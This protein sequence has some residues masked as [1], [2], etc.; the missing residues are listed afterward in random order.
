MLCV[1]DALLKIQLT[2]YNS[3]ELVP[4]SKFTRADG[5]KVGVNEVSV[6][7]LGGISAAVAK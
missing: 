5:V 4:V 1:N 6:P 3:L 2:G 7:F